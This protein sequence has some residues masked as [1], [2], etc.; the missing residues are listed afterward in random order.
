MSGRADTDLC[1][2][3]D[4]PDGGSNG[5]FV[6]TADGRL[7]YMAIRKGGDV[8][9]YVN[10]CPHTGMPLDFQPGR[11]LSADGALIQCSTHGAQFRIEDGFCVAGP[12]QGDRLTAV[13]TEIRDGR[14]Y[15]EPAGKPIPRAPL[16]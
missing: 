11:F 8:F 7:L 6:D 1:A 10:S 4:I 14:V 3:A 2:V 9:V 12:C 16:P 13:E 5:F 15:I